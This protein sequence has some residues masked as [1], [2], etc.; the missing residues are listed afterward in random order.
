MNN[1]KIVVIL[2]VG[3]SGTSFITSWLK[4]CG[5]NVGDNLVPPDKIA[6]TL[7]F[8]EDIDFAK[9]I[10]KIPF[11][12]R[13]LVEKIIPINPH[14]IITEKT[15]NEAADL[16][17]KKSRNNIQWG[18]KYP[19]TTHLW[20]KLWLPAF[21]KAQIDLSQ[22]II[23]YVYRDYF[24]YLNSAIRT[25]ELSRTNWFRK[26]FFKAILNKYVT[27]YFNDWLRLNNEMY[28]YLLKE[29]TIKSLVLN[30]SKIL[31]NS[32]SIYNYLTIECGLELQFVEPTTIFKNELYNRLPH[33]VSIDFSKL[34]TNA[35]DELM[36][37]LNSFSNPNK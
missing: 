28:D 17:L 7:G 5:L 23:V 15:I 37:K 29:K 18:W 10:E 16:L 25:T 20:H 4:A 19:R 6:N 8:F 32:N 9:F 27:S 22:V 36:V 33:Q 31:E 1:N 24:S 35:A 13:G 30:H 12:T 34:E 26:T 3:R 11:K 21:E 14:F 2:G